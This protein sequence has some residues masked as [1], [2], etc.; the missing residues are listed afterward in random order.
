MIILGVIPHDHIFH[1]MRQSLAVIQPSFFEGWSTTVEEA[2]SVGKRVI[3]SDISVHRE[4]NP[5]GA[6]F[7]DP[8]NPDAL[9]QC[10]TQV[11]RETAPGPDFEMEA[12]ARQR[13][14]ER[15][16]QFGRAFIEIVRQVEKV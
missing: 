10:L 2:K 11:M 7:F 16:R 12:S 4:Q 5:P 8:L 3:L 6:I 1:L 9:A 14:P 15:T 13:L